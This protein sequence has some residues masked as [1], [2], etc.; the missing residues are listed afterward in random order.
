MVEC[1]TLDCEHFCVS[2]GQGKGHCQCK[3]GY[4]LQLDG[5]HCDG[6]FFLCLCFF[7]HVCPLSVELMIDYHDFMRFRSSF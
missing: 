4:S 3:Y 5:R 1:D 6:I 2:E 7:V